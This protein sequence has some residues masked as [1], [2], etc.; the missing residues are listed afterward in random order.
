MAVILLVTLN[1]FDHQHYSEIEFIHTCSKPLRLSCDVTKCF[2]YSLYLCH[3]C[4]HEL[5]D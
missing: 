5:D 4:D 1:Y 2:D 3:E